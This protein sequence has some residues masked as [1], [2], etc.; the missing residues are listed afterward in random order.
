MNRFPLKGKKENLKFSQSNTQIMTAKRHSE[1]QVLGVA[2][3]SAFGWGHLQSLRGYR[4]L[5]D[6]CRPIFQQRKATT[7]LL[8]F[9]GLRNIAFARFLKI[10]RIPQTAAVAAFSR[11]AEHVTHPVVSHFQGS[12]SNPSFLVPPYGGLRRLPHFRGSERVPLVTAQPSLEMLEKLTNFSSP[13]LL[14]TATRLQLN[15]DSNR[16]QNHE[17][18]HIMSFGPPASRPRRQGSVP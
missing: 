18:V 12:L 2:P 9:P 17:N 11:V 13:K 16:E 6:R 4:R 8:L 5:F 1:L 3:G 7:Q 10:S 14:G 15:T